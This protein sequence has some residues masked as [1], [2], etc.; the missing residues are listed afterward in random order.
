MTVTNLSFNLVEISQFVY[1][2]VSVGLTVPGEYREQIVLV[3]K[4]KNMKKATSADLEK[5]PIASVVRDWIADNDWNDDVEVDDDRRRAT[6]RFGMKTN[7]Q[8]YSYYIETDEKTD[9]IYVYCY[10]EY[11]IPKVR[12]VD[13]SKLA[14][15]LNREW[16]F[17]R[18]ACSVDD[19]SSPVQ[20]LVAMDVENSKLSINQV[21]Q[22]VLS[23][24]QFYKMYGDLL[25]AV[26][27]TNLPLDQLWADFQAREN[28]AQGE[29]S[30]PTE[31]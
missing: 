20:F 3:N 11:E 31:L 14:N 5:M 13:F 10:S 9:R 19:D 2:C 1:V 25:A 28:G 30:V 18:I 4:E 7:N 15:I 29:D 23:A 26:A 17:G 6:C 8:S 24:N 16:L 27:L 21:R 12:F 22:M